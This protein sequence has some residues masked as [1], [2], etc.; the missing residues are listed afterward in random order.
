MLHNKISRFFAAS[1]FAALLVLT[2]CTP[3]APQESGPKLEDVHPLKASDG[4]I[5]TWVNDV[6]S[7]SYGEKYD[8]GT[9]YYNNYSRS[10]SNW[11]YHADQWFLYYST[12]NLKLY[13]INDTSGIIYAQFNDAEHIGASANVGQWY[14]LYYKNLTSNSVQIS[15]AFKTGGKLACDTLEKA[16][17]E[18]TI[19]NGYYGIF[20]TCINT[21]SNSQNVDNNLYFVRRSYK[22]PTDPNV[23]TDDTYWD[24]LVFTSIDA[25]EFNEVTYPVE[26]YQRV[27][28]EY[29]WKKED[30]FFYLY[31]EDDDKINGAEFTITSNKITRKAAFGI[32]FLEYFDYMYVE[33]E[34]E[35]VTDKGK[36][37]TAQTYPEN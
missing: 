33:E 30:E 22:D 19:E 1:L 16:V 15:Q 11:N 34:F 21:N 14:A 28:R 37:P 26:N 2:A 29:T 31:D 18:F 20:S 36:I 25:D 4:I 7:Q 8:I 10:D 35:L 5:G 6:P 12:N 27:R 32:D 17:S 24:I 13:K 9:S 23:L 3:E